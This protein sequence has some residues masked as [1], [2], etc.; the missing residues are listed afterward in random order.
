MP[1]PKIILIT[2]GLGYIGSHTIVELYNKNIFTLNKF[3]NEYKAIIVDDC[4]TC[5][6]KILPILEKMIGEKILFYK[7]SIVDKK[8]LEEI[9]EKH[10]IYAIIHFAGKKSVEE[11]VVEPLKYY[12]NNFIGTFNLIELCIKYKVQILFFQVLAL[13]MEIGKIGQ[14][15]MI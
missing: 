12:E 2:G 5:S 6:K 15:K 11:S 3:N 4:S 13:F 10:E 14:M 1:I 7:C 9:F 8:N